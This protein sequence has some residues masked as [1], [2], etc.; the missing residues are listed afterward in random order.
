MAD[1]CHFSGA[2]HCLWGDY[3]LAIYRSLAKEFR[4]GNWPTVAAV[5]DRVSVQKQVKWIGKHSE[6]TTYVA[7]LTYSYRNPESQ[8]GVYERSFVSEE[9]AQAWAKSLKGCTVMVHVDP[10]DPSH[11]VLCRKDLDTVADSG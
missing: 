2:A 8:T 4:G 7:V 9:Y 5:I 3:F 10:G 6:S 1:L 11:S